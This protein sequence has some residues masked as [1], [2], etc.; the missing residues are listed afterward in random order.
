M[1][2]NELI[3]GCMVRFAG[4]VATLQFG[5]AAASSTLVTCA[6]DLHIYQDPGPLM[7]SKWQQAILTPLVEV[8]LYTFLFYQSR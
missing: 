5:C 6:I 7:R 3:D 1:C 2:G 8:W 4:I